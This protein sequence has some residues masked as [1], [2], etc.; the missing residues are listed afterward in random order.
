MRKK[1][2]PALVF[3]DTTFRLGSSGWAVCLPCSFSCIYLSAAVFPQTGRHK[4]CSVCWQ[5]LPARAGVIPD[6][7]VAVQL[8]DQLGAALE[9]GLTTLALKSNLFLPIPDRHL[10]RY[11]LDGYNFSYLLILQCGDLNPCQSVELYQ[12]GTFEERSSN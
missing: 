4:P 7:K 2:L 1:M 10:S 6:L 11:S 9:P 12:T 8:L 5:P 3:D